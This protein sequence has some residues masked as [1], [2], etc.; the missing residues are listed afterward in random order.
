MQGTLIQLTA[1]AALICGQAFAQDPPRD[2]PWWKQG[3]INFMWGVW[4]LANPDTSVRPGW[5]R[6]VPRQ[7]FRNAAQAGATVFADTWQYSADHA[8][9]AQEFGLKYFPC[10]HLHH[11]EAVPGGGRAWITRTGD[12]GFRK[13]Q[14][15][16]QYP[17]KCPLDAGVW[18]R[19]LADER[20]VE[21]IRDGLVDAGRP[22]LTFCHESLFQHGAAPWKD[23]TRAAACSGARSS[24]ACCSPV[25]GRAAK[26]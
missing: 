12:P 8:R 10:S 14:D 6:S 1:V 19:W 11:I 16:P 18:E 23:G 25:R 24:T 2:T 21:G 20:K 4:G 9:L 26:N 5:A 7:T 13:G 22:I 3:K 17:L 15:N